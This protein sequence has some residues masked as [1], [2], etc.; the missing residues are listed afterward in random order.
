MDC[1][2]ETIQIGLAQYIYT[3]LLLFRISK[4]ILFQRGEISNFQ[5]LMHLNTLAGRSYN[6]LMQYPVFPWVLADYSS[7]KLDLTDPDTFR[8][9]S[10]PMGA[11]TPDR[12]N[13]FKKRFKEWDDPTGMK[14]YRYHILL[15]EASIPTML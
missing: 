13:Q 3:S 9:L 12:L 10:K 1:I 4:R 15:N 8:D 7:E 5:Y 2:L 14:S 6:D 11:L